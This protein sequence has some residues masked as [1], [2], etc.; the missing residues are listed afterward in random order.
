MSP[1]IPE[2]EIRP[3]QKTKNVTQDTKVVNF[4]TT[5]DTQKIEDDLLRFMT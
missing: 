4:I 3:G 2:V 5:K 1:L